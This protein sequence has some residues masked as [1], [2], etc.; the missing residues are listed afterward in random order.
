MDTITAK[1]IGVGPTTTKGRGEVCPYCRTRGR[2]D[3]RMRYRN[4]KE[5]YAVGC[6]ACNWRTA[7]FKTGKQAWQMWTQR[8][9]PRAEVA[10][11]CCCDD[12]YDDST[13][14]LGAQSGGRVNIS[15]SRGW[16][17]GGMKK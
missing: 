9:K 10:K 16:L 12:D 5:V 17:M 1:G 4:H 15:V 8:P 14:G 11:E 7:F 6:N 3:R 2:V 13:P